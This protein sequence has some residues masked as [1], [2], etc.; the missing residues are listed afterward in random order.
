VPAF[1]VA[2]RGEEPLSLAS[3]GAGVH[4]AACEHLL[5]RTLSLKVARGLLRR[6]GQIVLTEQTVTVIQPVEAIDIDL[7][8]AGLDADPGW[9]PWLG[10][11]LSFRFVGGEEGA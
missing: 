2:L 10:K 11:T 6:S 4:L 8:R 1:D 7:R 5:G 9:L 3:W